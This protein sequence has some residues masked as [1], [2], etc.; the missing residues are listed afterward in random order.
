[1]A[2]YSQNNIDMDTP[3]SVDDM[4]VSFTDY[5]KASITDAYETSPSTAIRRSKDI[6]ESQ[7]GSDTLADIMSHQDDMSFDPDSVVYTGKPALDIE[8]QQRRIDEAGLKG[9]IKPDAGY[10][11][12]ALNIIMQRRQEAN[13]R[14]FTRELAPDEW[15]PVGFATDLIVG[16]ADPLNIA[17][18]FMDPLWAAKK[19]FPSAAMRLGVDMIEGGAT[20]AWSLAARRAGMGALEGLSGAVA[21]EPLMYATQTQQQADYGMMNSLMNI[22][23]GAIM[24]GAMHP[25]MGALRD[26]RNA[27]R[28]RNNPLAHKP[29][30]TVA[31]TDESEAMR[32]ELARSAFE[33][34]QAAGSK[35]TADQIEAAAI[36]FDARA[37]S[38][39]YFEK[40]PVKEYYDTWTP[41]FRA[42]QLGEIPIDPQLEGTLGGELAPEAKPTAA[43]PAPVAQAPE[44]QPAAAP[45][46]QA[47]V[48]NATAVNGRVRGM[49][50]SV[51]T[52]AG[53]D[54]GYYEVRELGDIIASHDPENGY[55]VRGD[56]PENV[57]E[58]PYHSD[59]GEQDKVYRNALGLDPRYL[60][61]DNPDAVNGPPVITEG[62]IVLGGNSRSMSLQ[63]AYSQFGDR[64]HAYRTALRDQAARFGIDPAS[65]EGMQ[66]PV[67]VR[68]VEGVNTPEDM[69]RRSRLYNQSMT[70]GL[71]RGAEGVSRGRIMSPESM[72][73]L[74][75][76][77]EGNDKT[78][79]EWLDTGDGKRF[80]QALRKD[81]V[82]EET[83]L[84]RLLNKDGTLTDEG[85]GLVLT[86]LRGTVVPNADVLRAAPA[87]AL[88]KLD[89]AIPSLIRLKA[90]GEGWDITSHITEA[91]RILGDS[92]KTGRPL[93]QIFGQGSL[94]PTAPVKKSVQAL[95]FT[96][97][98][99][100]QKEM[101]IRM[102]AFADASA[103][104][105][106]NRGML[107]AGIQHTP[108]RGFVKS[109]LQPVAEVNGKG[110]LDFNPDMKVRDA[111]IRYAHD[112]GGRGHDPEKAMEKLYAAIRKGD[113]PP[114]QLAKAQDILGELANFS[115]PVHV[116]DAKTGDFFRYAQGEELFQSYSKLDE[117]HRQIVDRVID[118]RPDAAEIREQL[119]RHKGTPWESQTI[120]SIL[121]RA[122]LED[123]L[124]GRPM[125]AGSKMGGSSCAKM[126]QAIT[127][128]GPEGVWWY[129]TKNG[130][131][132]HAS[133][134][135]NAVNASYVNCRPSDNCA[136]YCY[137]ARGNY[138]YPVPAV[139]SEMITWAVEHDPVRAAK[140]VHREYTGMPEFELGKALR[141]FDK[142]DMNEKWI[143]FIEN[144]NKQGVRAQ[145]FSKRPDL[146]RKLDP[147]KNVL[148]L[149][150][151]RSNL[152]MADE[153][154]DLPIAFVYEGKD[155]IPFLEKNAQ[156]FKDRGGV[157]LPVVEG[158]GILSDEQ[159]SVLPKWTRPYTCPIDSGAR[160]LKY[161]EG[162]SAEDMKKMGSLWN[163]TRCDKN[164][165]L[166]C[167]FGRTGDLLKKYNPEEDLSKR[168]NIDDQIKQFRELADLVPQL[169]ADDRRRLLAA[170]DVLHAKILGSVDPAAEA[171]EVSSYSRL[172]ARESGRT[173]E[174]GS[175]RGVDELNQGDLYQ[176]LGEK[177]VRQAAKRKE[178]YRERVDALDIAVKMEKA[179]KPD[180]AIRMAT[181]WERGA[182][183]K[184]RYEIGDGSF[185][186]SSMQSVSKMLAPERLTAP[187]GAYRSGK[188]SDVLVNKELYDAYPE[189]GNMRVYTKTL[190]PNHYGSHCTVRNAR[191]GKVVG[192]Y[193]ILN[194][195]YAKKG[196]D[197]FHLDETFRTLLHE[198]QH[199]IQGIEGFTPGSN[200]NRAGGFDNYNHV[201]GEIEARNVAAR[202][203]KTPEERRKTLLAGT[204]EYPRSSQLTP[205]GLPLN[206]REV[207]GPY[208]PKDLKP[209][210]IAIEERPLGEKPKR[211]RT[212][213]PKEAPVEEPKPTTEPKPTEEA[214]AEP[215]KPVEPEPEVEEPEPQ[216]PPREEI[217]PESLP[218]VEPTEEPAPEAA[219]A[220]P[221]PEAMTP[222]GK[223]TFMEDGKAV[224]TFFKN[225]DASTLPHELF[226]VFRRE[227]AATAAMENASTHAKEQYAKLCEFVG[228]DPDKAW[229]TD[230]YSREQIRG[231]EEKF[232]DAA[233]RYLLS[234]RSPEP[235][236]DETFARMKEWFE[237]IYADADAAGLEIS[238][239]MRKLFDGMFQMSPEDSEA[240][241][242]YGLGKLLTHDPTEGMDTSVP[243]MAD[244][245]DAKA[246]EE[247]VA[248]A[249]Q[250]I[251]ES[252][253]AMQ[254][255][256]E[257]AD[258]IRKEYEAEVAEYDAA[259]N[260]AKNEGDILLEAAI[261][262]MRN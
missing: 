11:E 140:I 86:M 228:A 241:F 178:E 99:A 3:L 51:K 59:A 177:G 158:K 202:S 36:Q 159:I 34:A 65:F 161:P 144:L 137:A 82:I 97:K 43:E 118:A 242:R 248:A 232:A 215:A 39:S 138:A 109:F 257:V 71:E 214:P 107:L 21:M 104:T 205:E 112:N 1:M 128:K 7:I 80:I 252:L 94:I 163:C 10:N 207:N 231:F 223:T 239:E 61:T 150:V 13:D 116:Y 170:M 27:W 122:D 18:T 168:V 127:E 172:D 221:A 121:I 224:I 96:L 175:G 74:A 249:D 114:D 53:E 98:N 238:D 227:M 152:A 187:E 55:A 76:G 26:W 108:E 142:G 189:L 135:V 85:K 30:E 29:W 123:L 24:G 52:P 17:A 132:G 83:Q 240:A 40:R 174:P 261:C 50:I 157:I 70:Q 46:V 193:I 75:R 72:E 23:F 218:E 236:L 235:A 126:R 129:L 251:R 102:S 64:A 190:P 182:D 206:A 243:P 68:V 156:R 57:Q 106:R 117:Y 139:K 73:I 246:M 208:L 133:K 258:T 148:M 28:N 245:A 164:G 188:L 244:A 6:F 111:A 210:D 155:D 14:A 79:R 62:G 225:A 12:D 160:P 166:G 256:P 226:H 151:D 91:L 213:K 179:G 145:I 77:V 141:L 199:A 181:G 209:E 250:G 204:E 101:Q 49:D 37:R 194:S 48:P 56:Y 89:R 216:L 198:V 217:D 153:N 88:N 254:D 81:G 220:E 58:R 110:I 90:R 63:L 143:P 203:G 38:W 219:P 9:M 105:E 154:P 149:S 255:V 33:A 100:S 229:T 222:R 41:Q 16:A 115:G 2:L 186:F 78:L 4:D 130:I 92:E 32:R 185:N 184:W 19:I 147:K 84:S 237:E 191:S 25:A 125:M 5:L 131:V 66:R 103:Q 69:A 262:D 211:K 44:A 196:V 124:A 173:A 234:G 247:Q 192:E 47:P 54:R 120:E 201:G 169:S 35:I 136:K 8:E 212:K 134:P 60:I 200:M 113:M 176:I 67:L 233:E 253:E 162:A 87:S 171:G 183:G 180:L 15:A 93:E 45:E 259:I 165:G 195:R 197:Q 20:G 119:T 260:R 230:N 31:P 42:E 146:L 22:G 167:F 95:A